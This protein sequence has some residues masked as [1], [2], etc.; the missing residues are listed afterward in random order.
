MS[1]DNFPVHFLS[2]FQPAMFFT[3]GKA[4]PREAVTSGREVN[5][6][7]LIAVPLY[8]WDRLVVA[9]V[10]NSPLHNFEWPTCVNMTIT[11]LSS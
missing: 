9:F 11:S 1:L 8:K 2:L 4:N 3:K 7:C 6:K 5:H 10:Q